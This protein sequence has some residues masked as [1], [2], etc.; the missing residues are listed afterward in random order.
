MITALDI[1]YGQKETRG[2]LQAQPGLP[3]GL[4]DAGPGGAA[5]SASRLSGCSPA[6]IQMVGVRA[7]VPP[8]DGDGAGVAAA[9][10]CGS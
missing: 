7:E 3:F 9:D 10:L 2:L 5:R 4:T 8:M 6:A 1:A